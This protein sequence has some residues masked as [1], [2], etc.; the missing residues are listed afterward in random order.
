HGSGARRWVFRALKGEHLNF[1][2]AYMH[3]NTTDYHGE[4]TAPKTKAA[5]RYIYLPTHMMDDLQNYLTWYKENNIYKDNYVL[6]GTLFKAFSESTIDRWCT[7]TLKL[8]DD[9]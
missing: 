8:L 7:G 5:I 1:E 2:S 9:E 6:F 4:V 3:I